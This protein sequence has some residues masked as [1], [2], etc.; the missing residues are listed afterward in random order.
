VIRLLLAALLLSAAPASAQQ[1]RDFSRRRAAAPVEASPV[2][3]S[4]NLAFSTTFWQEVQVSTAGA[5]SDL[6]LLSK[7]GFY[8]L[9][10]IELVLL[11]RQGHQPL[12]TTVEKRKKGESLADIAAAYRVDFSKLQEAALAVQELIEE[13][14]LPLYPEKRPRREKEEW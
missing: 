5:V 13:R 9:E 3:L 2:A 14:Y 1:V 4:L 7:E 10:I 8:K 11:S 12:K 6:S